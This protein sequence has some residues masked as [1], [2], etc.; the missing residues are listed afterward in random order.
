MKSMAVVDCDCK[1]QLSSEVVLGYANKIKKEKKRKNN[2]YLL[3]VFN[4][5]GKTT[6]FGFECEKCPIKLT[7][8][9]IFKMLNIHI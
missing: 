6:P 1:S 2:L 3:F 4:E 8:L 5:K 9:N 7:K